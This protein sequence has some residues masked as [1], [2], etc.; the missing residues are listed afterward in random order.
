MYLKPE[1]PEFDR[2]LASFDC[3]EE[4]VDEARERYQIALEDA[5]SAIEDSDERLSE[6]V[7][8]DPELLILIRACMAGDGERCRETVDKMVMRAADIDAKE[9]LN[10]MSTYE[11]MRHDAQQEAVW[12]A[13]QRTPAGIR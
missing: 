12:E 10:N 6:V 5:A 7:I 8:N 13:H 2:W 11:D 1:S 3:G 4:T 9:S